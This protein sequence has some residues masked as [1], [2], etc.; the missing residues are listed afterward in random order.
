MNARTRRDAR[1]EKSSKGVDVLGYR[2]KN[3]LTNIC[4]C[5]ALKHLRMKLG[6]AAERDLSHT[7]VR[8]DVRQI[9]HQ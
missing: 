8:P 6:G 9:T 2:E 4:R 1:Y 3:E 7:L 5:D